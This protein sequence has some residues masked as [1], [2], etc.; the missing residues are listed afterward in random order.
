[1]IHGARPAHLQI[2]HARYVLQRGLQGHDTIISATSHSAQLN[3]SHCNTNRLLTRCHSGCS[4][5]MALSSR[6]PRYLEGERQ[7][8]ADGAADLGAVHVGSS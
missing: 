3:G 2:R 6:G 4:R 7:T 1:M 5:S 8:E